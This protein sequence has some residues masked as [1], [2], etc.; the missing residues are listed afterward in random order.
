MDS[1]GIRH[2]TPYNLR[3]SRPLTGIA[4]SSD[5]FPGR[6]HRTVTTVT[7]ACQPTIT[8]ATVSSTSS[9][10]VS[11]VESMSN[12]LQYEG[13]VSLQ[14]DDEND[15][16]PFEAS[17]AQGARP[18]VSN[19]S[20]LVS[21]GSAMVTNTPATSQVSTLSG[22]FTQSMGGNFPIGNP[23]RISDLSDYRL[24]GLRHGYYGQEARSD[25]QAQ[26]NLPPWL[27]T[28][29]NRAGQNEFPPCPKQVSVT[30]IRGLVKDGRY[31]RPG[32]LNP[33][34]QVNSEC[35][36]ENSDQD[37]HLSLIDSLVTVMQKGF[38]E[39][40]DSIR[41]VKGS[42]TEMKCSVS[43]VKGSVTEISQRMDEVERKVAD[44][45]EGRIDRRR[46]SDELYRNIHRT[47]A[48]DTD[49]SRIVSSS[50]NVLPRTISDNGR[51]QFYRES[52][53]PPAA[54]PRIQTSKQS[55][56]LR[57]TFSSASSRPAGR[58]SLQLPK[59][60]GKTDYLA[61]EATFL[62]VAKQCQWDPSTCAE[63]MGCALEGSAQKFY[64]RLPEPNRYDFPWLLDTLKKRYN[65]QFPEISREKL[66]NRTRQ[67]SETVVDLKDDIWRLVQE[68]YP[69]MD[70]RSQESFA[71]DCFKR[72][73]DKEI[74][75]RL[76]DKQVVRLQQAVEVAE[77]YESIMRPTVL[78]EKPKRKVFAAQVEDEIVT[79]TFDV[80]HVQAKSNPSKQASP[81]LSK[82][83]KELAD[84]KTEMN[85]ILG[86]VETLGESATEGRRQSQSES[87]G[88]FRPRD[89]SSVV[90]YNCSEKGHYSRTCPQ[91]KKE[92]QENCQTPG[93]A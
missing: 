69:D 79:E 84:L 15:V 1:P 48:D 46:N 10:H 16:G 81:G 29:S 86:K 23:R 3:S 93:Q 35:R 22:E 57:G 41:E 76:T 14:I 77:L 82:L 8:C 9:A 45:V 59:F 30:E 4:L 6:N 21:S 90:C 13:A 62:N 12:S 37:L 56:P 80:N 32:Q 19:P 72:A 39:M 34:S 73:L 43:E 85:K 53:V 51:N 52:S 75:L 24:I 74:R 7:M 88:R 64:A 33:V 26:E 44:I 5:G 20:F 68:A 67:P 18:K 87:S 31:C 42:V 47:L 78:Q 2:T 54:G 27:E 11:Q 40:R 17:L 38:S 36:K 89:M 65:R 28:S 63:M 49:S 83:E 50:E 25:C 61:F 55:F 91:P 71:V 58:V 66:A 70:H 60:S 92:R